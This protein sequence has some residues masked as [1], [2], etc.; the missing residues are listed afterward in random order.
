MSLEKSGFGSTFDH[1]CVLN[2]SGEQLLRIMV[3]SVCADPEEE[4]SLF[5]PPEGMLLIVGSTGYKTIVVVSGSNWTTLI[6]ERS[7]ITVV[8]VRFTNMFPKSVSLYYSLMC[9]PNP[10]AFLSSSMSSSIDLGI[11]LRS[12]ILT[13]L[14]SCCN[15]CHGALSKRDRDM[16]RGNE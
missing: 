1:C 10:H 13:L 3:S 5:C 7:V 6:T 8:E 2:D 9:P 11:P 15:I 14:S 12:S 16:V 4:S